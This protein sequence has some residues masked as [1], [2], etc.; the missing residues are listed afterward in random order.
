MLNELR[1]CEEKRKDQEADRLTIMCCYLRFLCPKRIYNISDDQTEFQINDRKRFMRFLGLS[2]GDKVPDAKTIWLF[3]EN[4]TRTDTIQKLFD[5]FD[6]M[7]AT[8][9]IITHT[10]TMVDATFIDAPRQRNTREENKKMK[11]GETPEEWLVKTQKAKHKKT[12]KDVDAS[13]TKGKERHYGYK[14]HAKVDADS[15]MILD[16]AVTDASVHDSNEFVEF[17]NETDRV[18]YADS[19]YTS[20][21]ISASLP[22]H[23]EQ[24]IHEK[25]YRNH[26]LTA[27]QKATNRVKSKVRVRIEHVFGFMTNSMHGLHLHSLGMKR[28]KNNI[29]FINLVY[30]L[31]RYAFL[32]KKRLLTE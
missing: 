10:G 12:Q 17:F 16:Y 29:G 19:A 27:S 32:K 7:L 6:E 23:V 24:R 28:A 18:A 3:R 14:N 15:K 30:N 13:V 21:K 20:A 9:N 22:K 4:L 2:L 25:G 26:P 8:Q 5:K 31:F 11:E 1:H